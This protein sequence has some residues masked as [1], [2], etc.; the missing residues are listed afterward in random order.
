MDNLLRKTLN[1]NTW[2]FVVDRSGNMYVGIKQ[3]GKFQHSSFLAGSHVLAAGLLKV[4]QG[5]LTSL[6]PLSGHYR[7]GSDQFKAFV[8]ILEHEWRCDMSR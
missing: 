2:I 7:A 4:D 5:Q 8:R 6:S 1:A 3:T